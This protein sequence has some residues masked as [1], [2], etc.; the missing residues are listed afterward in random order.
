MRYYT[1]FLKKYILAQNDATNYHI[2]SLIINH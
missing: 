2:K 1:I